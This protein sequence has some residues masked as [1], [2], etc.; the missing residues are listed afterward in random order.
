M[1]LKGEELEY[2][3]VNKAFCEITGRRQRDILGTRARDIF[4]KDVARKL[5]TMDLLV[6][7]SLK[8]SVEEVTID[9]RI[10]EMRKFPVNLQRSGSHRRKR[11][12][13]YSKGRSRRRLFCRR[14]YG[15]RSSPTTP[16]S[17]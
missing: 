3:F 16:L 13:Y 2:L 6:L 17:A 7:A 4:P 15:S 10:Y 14:R 11:K 5:E 12:R 1:A 8:E 9:G